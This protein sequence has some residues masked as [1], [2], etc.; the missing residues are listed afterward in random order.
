MNKKLIFFDGD[1]TLWYPKATKRTKKSHWIYND[2]TTMDNYLDHLELT[3]GTKQAL[4]VLKSRGMHLVVISANP[5]DQEV[6]LAD[7]N[8]RI[9]HFGLT[10]LFHSYYASRGDDPSGKSAIMLSVIEDLG[11]SKSEALMV[12]DNFFY[13]YLAA[14]NIGVDAYFIDNTI[15]AMP[16]VAPI[17][18]ETIREIEDL[19]KILK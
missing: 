10:D 4:E 19:L 11:F 5:Y 12:G 17:D 16:E 14:K 7:I 2:P 18:F 6:A 15:S 3:P 9:V 13:D 1:G 8:E